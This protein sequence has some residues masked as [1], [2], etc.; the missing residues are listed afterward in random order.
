MRGL[1]L[2][3]LQ[4]MLKKFLNKMGL[5]V[6]FIV[7]LLLYYPS[8]FNYFTH[9]D[10]FVFNIA[11]A[12]SLKEVLQFFYLSPGGW[13]LYRPISTQLFYFIYKSLFGFN[14][15][16]MH[17]LLFVI[18]FVIV[19]LVY[20]IAYSI[21]KKINTSLFTTFLYATSATHFGQLYF[22]ATQELW[23]GLFYFCSVWLFI[24][25]I[26]EQKKKLYP[27]SILVFVLALMSKEVAL[28]LPFV[29]LFVHCLFKKKL[30]I[31]EII[32]L[33]LPYL[34]IVIVYLIF[35]YFYYG[36]TSGD[37]YVWDVTFRVF[38]TLIWYSL[39]SLNLP[40]MLV[41]FIGPGLRINPNLL[42]YWQSEM[43][44]IIIPF[45]FAFLMLL[46]KL[47]KNIKEVKKEYRIYLFG[48]IWFSA[49][50]VTVL[51]LPLHKFTFYLTIPL[52]GL[53]IIISKLFEKSSKAVI[54][55]FSF[56]WLFTSYQTLNL[57]RSTHW[58]V[59]GGQ[60]AQRINNFMKDRIVGDKKIRIIHF[61]DLKEDLD[62]P[63][64]PSSLVK[65]AL[66]DNNFFKALYNGYY[67]A[68]FGKSCQVSKQE[69]IYVRARLFIGY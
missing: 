58:I 6:I 11:K 27:L 66:S 39:W 28:T 32:K 60:I 33:L 34:F 61:C 43:L 8:L 49:T 18:F 35:R 41:D 7:S 5:S 17:V 16:W 10:F 13:G 53:V 21:T 52:F 47:V 25:Y 12:S 54:I 46:S 59:R 30:I 24:R 31:K 4:I 14:P 23:V 2:I 40:E 9:D 68:D 20:K 37:S 51:F 56:F 26:L 19:Y 63:W 62:L 44:L 64:R 38:N 45:I 55:I 15:F 22:P 48:L 36:F 3:S 65:E 50:L 67:K 57:T 42:R 69:E 29:L 1:L